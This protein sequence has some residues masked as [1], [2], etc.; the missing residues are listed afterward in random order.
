MKCKRSFKKH[1]VFCILSIG[2]IN[3]LFLYFPTYETR[4][5]VET[6]LKLQR[7]YGR[8]SSAFPCICTLH[9][10]RNLRQSIPARYLR[11]IIDIIYERLQHEHVY[12]FTHTYTHITYV[13]PYPYNGLY[14]C[15]IS[16]CI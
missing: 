11:E 7:K 6:H 3:C 5:I 8:S 16:E 4:A 2:E 14:L 15:T 1:R 13:E 10:R 12:E 9:S